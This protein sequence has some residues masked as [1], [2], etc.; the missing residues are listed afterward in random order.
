M[1]INDIEKVKKKSSLL[2]FA[3]D[4]LVYLISDKLITYSNVLIIYIN[5]DLENGFKNGL[6]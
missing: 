2:I 3:V 4:K 1:Y 5:N 6:N